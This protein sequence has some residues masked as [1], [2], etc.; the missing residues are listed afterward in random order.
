MHI[1]EKIV[2][3]N[4]PALFA[5]TMISAK[6]YCA[7]GA[8]PLRQDARWANLAPLTLGVPNVVL[9]L[10]LTPGTSGGRVAIQTYLWTLVATQP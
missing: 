2:D 3:I 4:Q 1:R 8:L 10:S 6:N 9:P 5:A 7:S